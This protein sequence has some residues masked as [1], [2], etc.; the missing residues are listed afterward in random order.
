M[1][2]IDGLICGIEVVDIGKVIV[3]FIGDVIKG[4]FFNVVGE[5]IDGI[6]EVFKE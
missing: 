5:V 4:C 1:D 2:V 6:G 3:M